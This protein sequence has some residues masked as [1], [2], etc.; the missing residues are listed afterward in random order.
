MSTSTQSELAEAMV[1][2]VREHQDRPVYVATVI[3]AFSPDA[4]DA[5]NV[6]LTILELIAGHRIT[7]GP[8]LDLRVDAA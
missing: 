6:R 2:Y 3:A 7:L 5:Q 4:T 1:R 8:A